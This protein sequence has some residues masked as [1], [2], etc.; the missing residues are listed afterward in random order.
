M[1]VM[2]GQ[3]ARA[4]IKL[5]RRPSLGA[6]RQAHDL[7]A[8]RLKA[9]GDKRGRAALDELRGRYEKKREKIRAACASTAG[10]S[11]TSAEDTPRPT[12]SLKSL[13]KIC[14]RP[15]EIA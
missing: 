12:K 8:K 11:T 14:I 3:A 15:F 2:P 5:N 7:L 10:L 13:K 6:A 9:N 4:G 1:D